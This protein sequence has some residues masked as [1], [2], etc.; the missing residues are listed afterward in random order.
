MLKIALVSDSTC[1]IPPELVISQQIHVVP[2]ILI[3]DG[4]SIEDN[5]EFSRQEFY[6]KLPG[7]TSMPTTSTASVGTYQALYENLFQKGFDHVISIHCFSQFSGIFNAANTAAQS[8]S[9]K[10]HVVDS[11]QV[12]LG[13]GFQV[14]EAAQ[15]IANGETL[16][17]L[18]VLLKQTRERVRLIAMLD[19]LEYIRRSGRISWARASLGAMLNMKPF[20]EVKDGNIL[21]LG[22]VRSR[23]KGIARLL[24]LMQSHEPLKRFAL[25]HSNAEDDARRL[26]EKLAPEVPT[27]PLIVNVNPV[28]GTHVGPN[29][30]GFA[31]L[32]QGESPV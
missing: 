2:N 6:E 29:G 14:L 3:I 18:L 28:L 19:S 12:S 8:Y 25:L 23:K 26:L 5:W 4:K 20:V 30:L 7:M 16:E 13:L 15:A 21:N 1:D 10:A 11:R 32:L 27:P 17:S 24:E 9:H 22:S 31:A